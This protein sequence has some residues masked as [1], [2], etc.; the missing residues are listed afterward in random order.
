MPV[1][2]IAAHRPVAGRLA[3]RLLAEGGEVRAVASDGV[4]ALRAEGIHVADADADDPGRIEAAATRVH[5]VVHLAGGLAGADPDRVLAEGLAV[6]RAAE[7]AAVRRLVLVTAAGSAPGSA[8]PV[9][10]AHAAIEAAALAVAVPSIV[11]RAPVVDTPRL[12]ALLRGLDVEERARIGAVPMV[13]ADDLVE[14]LVALD[15][16]RSSAREGHVVLAAAAPTRPA[17]VGAGGDR[18]GAVVLAARER[19]RL[20]ASLEGP[21]EDPEPGL[22]DAW[23]LMDVVPRPVEP[24]ARSEVAR[25]T[26]PGAGADVGAGDA[27]GPDGA[28]SVS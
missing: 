14:L 13:R 26:A 5:T 11:V 10:A 28:G 12:R 9:R 21:W 17:L 8:D 4:G 27:P 7:G 3:R 15:R 22:P 18:L 24:E 2:V 16:A 25:G 6:V 19:E 20:V 23:A 1:L